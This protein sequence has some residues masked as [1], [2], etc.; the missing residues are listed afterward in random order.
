MTTVDKLKNMFT[1]VETDQD[2]KVSEQTHIKNLLFIREIFKNDIDDWVQ[3][4]KGKKTVYDEE[5]VESL[6]DLSL[7]EE[8]LIRAY[9]NDFEGI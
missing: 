9:S 8:C 6:E 4:A 7:V 1:V 2:K 5:V 3:E